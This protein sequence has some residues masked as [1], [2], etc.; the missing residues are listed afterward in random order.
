M[1]TVFWLNLL[2]G[3]TVLGWILAMVKAA[4]PHNAVVVSRSRS[5]SQVTR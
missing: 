3:W 1:P 5:P 2:I 4:A